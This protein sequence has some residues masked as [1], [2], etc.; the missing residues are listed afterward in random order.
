MISLFPLPVGD[1]LSNAA[2]VL[3]FH[4]YFMRGRGKRITLTGKERSGI[5]FPLHFGAIFVY[6]FSHSSDRPKYAKE[7]SIIAQ[8]FSM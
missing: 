6:Y 2:A 3:F 5:T 8:D 4:H 7:I 1:S